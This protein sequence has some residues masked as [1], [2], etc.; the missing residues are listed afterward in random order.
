MVEQ[1]V[2]RTEN[3]ETAAARAENTKFR[4][5]AY[6]QAEYFSKKPGFPVHHYLSVAIPFPPQMFAGEPPSK[7]IIDCAP[8]SEISSGYDHA[9][10]Y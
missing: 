10:R 2:L 5:R 7:Y 1:Q 8:V 9:R 4:G 6:I 3:V